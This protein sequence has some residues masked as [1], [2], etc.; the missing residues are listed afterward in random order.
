MYTSIFI[1]VA[2]LLGGS[3]YGYYKAASIASLV[4]GVSFAILITIFT[5]LLRQGKAWAGQVL[6]VVVLA[7]D[8][9]FSWRYMKTHKLMP[10]GLFSILTSILLIIIYLRLKKRSS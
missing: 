8:F 10:A 7:L 1:Y 6:L 2:L 9:A 3:F 4:M 5:L